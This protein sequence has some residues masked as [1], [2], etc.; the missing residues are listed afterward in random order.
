MFFMC[1]CSNKILL[2]LQGRLTPIVGENNLAAFHQWLIF[3]IYEY[4]ASQ[5]LQISFSKKFQQ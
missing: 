3:I 2:K 1:S 4:G 5:C